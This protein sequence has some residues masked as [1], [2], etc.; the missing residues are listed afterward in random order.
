MDSLG[1]FPEKYGQCMRSG[2]CYFKGLNPNN[3]SRTDI[4]VG[5]IK[6]NEASK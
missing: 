1:R 6:V 2:K 3:I 5:G 4:G